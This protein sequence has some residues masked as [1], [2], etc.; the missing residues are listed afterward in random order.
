ME[1]IYGKQKDN[2]VRKKP[3]P[4]LNVTGLTGGITP[5][6]VGSPNLLKNEMPTLAQVL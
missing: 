1:T 5:I 2:V 3:G 4:R 6:G